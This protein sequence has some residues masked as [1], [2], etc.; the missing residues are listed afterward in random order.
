VKIYTIVD[1]KQINRIYAKN[2]INFLEYYRSQKWDE[3]LN[4]IKVLETAFKG[5]LTYY[6]HMMQ[7]RIEELRK[8]NLDVNWDGV[9]VATSK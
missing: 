6:Y 1:D 2:H 9:Y 7:E 4:T 8:S 3:A 5:E